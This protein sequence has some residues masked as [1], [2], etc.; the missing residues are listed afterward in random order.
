MDDLPMNATFSFG[1]NLTSEFEQENELEQMEEARFRQE[2]EALNRSPTK[3]AGKRSRFDE[4]LKQASSPYGQDIAAAGT[5]DAREIMKLAQMLRRV[6]SENRSLADTLCRSEGD[7]RIL[8]NELQEVKERL[9][10]AQ[11]METL[12]RE[13]ENLATEKLSRTAMQLAESKEKVSHLN[14]ELGQAAEELSQLTVR[15]DDSEQRWHSTTE[16]LAT[17][18]FERDECRKQLG[19]LR[20]QLREVENATHNQLERYQTAI[21]ETEKRCCLLSEQCE[22]L[23]GEKRMLQGQVDE[24]QAAIGQRENEL[25]SLQRSYLECNERIAELSENQATTETLLATLKDARDAVE[26]KLYTTESCYKEDQAKLEKSLRDR[27]QL[28]ELLSI[29]TSDLTKFQRSINNISCSLAEACCERDSLTDKLGKAQLQLEESLKTWQLRL[30]QKQSDLERKENECR[31]LIMELA[32]LS[33][34]KC[35]SDQ[36]IERIHDDL[37]RTENEL[38]TLKRSY[39]ECNERLA[40]LAESISDKDARLSQTA[41]A[42]KAMERTTLMTEARLVEVQ[43]RLETVRCERDMLGEKVSNIEL[44]LTKKNEE[45]E[46]QKNFYQQEVERSQELLK[47]AE[48]QLNSLKMSY[49]QCNNRLAEVSELNSCNEGRLTELTTARDSA[50]LK[51]SE[52]ELLLVEMQNNLSVMQRERDGLEKTLIK[53]ESELSDMATECLAVKKA[54]ETE[55][56]EKETRNEELQKNLDQVTSSVDRMTTLLVSELVNLRR[57]LQHSLASPSHL[58]DQAQAS[59]PLDGQLTDSIQGELRL[60]KELVPVTCNVLH[61]VAGRMDVARREIQR[62]GNELLSLNRAEAAISRDLEEERQQSNLLLRKVTESEMRNDSLENEL[63]NTQKEFHKA[64]AEIAVV[65]G[66]LNRL[67]GEKAELQN[68]FD[69]RIARAEEGKGELRDRLVHSNKSINS[70]KKKFDAASE[71]L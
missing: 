6:E 32:E 64:R 56:K 26:E 3:E 43:A 70:L 34:A 63:V 31:S 15:L 47:E 54:T 39:L 10:A 12:A 49:L 50:E 14:R 8:Q 17:T 42:R 2:R 59:V 7:C 13:G 53:T 36:K 58:W 57:Q 45:V 46:S 21:A 41:E 67:E 52:T 61:S 5:V 51:L 44:A 35:I 69:K 60:W 28:S 20:S 18:R 22:K 19:A 4:S 1:K 24:L 55:L 11:Q 62:L 23:D 38:N 29:R 37:K 65:R 16:S 68:V 33:E 66:D 27:Q 25:N 9:A 30:D 48:D 40:E 71:E